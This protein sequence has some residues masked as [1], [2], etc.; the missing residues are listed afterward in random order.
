MEINFKK[1]FFIL[2]VI[3]G[4]AVYIDSHYT[5]KDVLEYS[6]KHPDPSLSPKV[7]YYVAMAYSLRSKDAESIFAFQQLLTD[8]P[9]CQYAP[10]ALILLG[11]AYSEKNRW[12]DA[13]DSYQRYIDQF[14]EGPDIE[15]ARK[16]YEIIKYR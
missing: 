13:R 9:T 14:P 7:D 1:W 2:A 6:Q 4:L 11:N 5:L 12:D 3:A 16:K 10:R 15:I 8:Y